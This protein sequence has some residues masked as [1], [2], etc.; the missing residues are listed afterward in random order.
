MYAALPLKR[1]LAILGY[2]AILTF[3]ILAIICGTPQNVMDAGKLSV[4]AISAWGF[5]LLVS[6]TSSA[7]WSPWRLLWRAIP[8]LNRIVFPDLN[9]TWRGMTQS[10][11]AP[12]EAMLH[13]AE[14][15]SGLIARDDLSNIQLR[16]DPIE[17]FI[18]ASFFK[19][20]IK[21]KLL[22]TSGTSHSVSENICYNEKLEQFEL[23]Y[24]YRQDTPLP[25]ASDHTSHYG[26][27]TLVL[28][29]DTWQ[30][31]GN[32]WTMRSWRSGLNT[33]G[34]LEVTRA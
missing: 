17:I 21:A 14:G 25:Q 33:A 1:L 4:N 12:I 3:V 27:A 13:A 23:Y 34:R 29:L 5:V 28:D 7:W 18:R 11:W 32:Y 8:P 6:G 31:S 9:G 2:P 16:E 10:N 20:V 24:V 26:A 22:S 30:L 15:R 19:F